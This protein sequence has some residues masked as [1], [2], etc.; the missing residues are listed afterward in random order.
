MAEARLSTRQFDIN[1][2]GHDEMTAGSLQ[3]LQSFRVH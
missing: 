3:G 2:V 1:Q